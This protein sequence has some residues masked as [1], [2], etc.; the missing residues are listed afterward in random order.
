M[1]KNPQNLA[2]LANFCP[3]RGRSKILTTDIHFQDKL[4]KT[5]EAQDNTKLACKQNCLVFRCSIIE[6]EIK[7]KNISA[8]QSHLEDDAMSPPLSLDLTLPKRQVY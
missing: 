2:C 4:F 8:R 7:S 5:S 1:R 6:M 3:V